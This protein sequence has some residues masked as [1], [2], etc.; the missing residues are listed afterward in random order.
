MAAPP[1]I[2]DLVKVYKLQYAPSTASVTL[3]DAPK[4]IGSSS[5]SKPSHGTQQS[6]GGSFPGIKMAGRPG[7]LSNDD[8]APLNSLIQAMLTNNI[9]IPGPPQPSQNARSFQF[10]KFKEEGNKKFKAGNNADAI[11]MYTLAAD[12][13][14][15]RPLFESSQY[16]R[17]ELSVA[18]SNRSA[19]YLNAGQNVEALAD[20]ETV[21][22]LKRN[23][24]KGHFRKAKALVA[25][26]RLFDARDAL[27][28]GLEFEPDNELCNALDTLD[29]Q[30]MAQHETAP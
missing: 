10:N 18:L 13:A 1:A 25:F 29:K 16:I 20:A 14:S 24:D 22:K 30:I 8:L 27:L 11:K 7:L 23:W 9:A 19:A 6:F 12:L 3:V 21:I 4:A 15:S 26:G 17:E 5:L 28:L 2:D